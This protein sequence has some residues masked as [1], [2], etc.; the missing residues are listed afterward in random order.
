MKRLSEYRVVVFFLKISLDGYCAPKTEGV[1]EYK[2][3]TLKARVRSGKERA[4]S[5]EGTCSFQMVCIISYVVFVLQKTN[6]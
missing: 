2:Q 5:E 1:L 3:V 6:T 4:H